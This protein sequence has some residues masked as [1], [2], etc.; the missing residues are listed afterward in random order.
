[1]PW[2]KDLE[3]SYDYQQKIRSYLIDCVAC[4]SP[5]TPKER[6]ENGGMCKHCYEEKVKKGY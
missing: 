4:E 1:M 3:K 5:I 6:D 2:S